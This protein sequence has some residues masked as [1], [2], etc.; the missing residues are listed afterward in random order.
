MM[1]LIDLDGFKPTSALYPLNG[2]EALGFLTAMLALI[3]AGLILLTH[4]ISEP[5]ERLTG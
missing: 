5:V 4:S 3:L 2:N 1:W